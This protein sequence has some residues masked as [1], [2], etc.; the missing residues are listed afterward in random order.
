MARPVTYKIDGL[1][2]VVQFDTHPPVGSRFDIPAG[3]GAI[4]ALEV[5]E[6]G[7]LKQLVTFKIVT[8]K[9]PEYHPEDDWGSDE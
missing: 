8:N 1:D 7:V 9:E 6:K 4:M 3:V 2:A 5:A